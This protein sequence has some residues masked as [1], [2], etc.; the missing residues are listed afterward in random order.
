MH[1]KIIVL[2]IASVFTF[3]F[4]SFA[5]KEETT[6]QAFSTM[7]KLVESK[8]YIFQAEHMLPTS[9]PT[10]Y[11][12]D[13]YSLTVKNNKAIADLP[14]YGQVY[15]YTYGEDGGIKF[16]N[17]YSNY[18]TQIKENKQKIIV[19]FKVKGDND[20]YRCHL[21][22]TKTGSSTL[23]VQGNNKQTIQY[24]GDLKQLK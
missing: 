14:Y 12:T 18:N 19:E 1:N 10:K 8:Q 7:Q 23:S 22:V 6:G 13:D 16:N 15:N 5:Q 17:E 21:T 20:Y 2:I 9:G 3:S 24:W 4:D 11:L